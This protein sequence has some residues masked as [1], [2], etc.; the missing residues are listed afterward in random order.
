MKY[1]VLCIIVSYYPD[2]DIFVSNIHALLG[3][4][5]KLLIWENTPAKE[6]SKYRYIRSEKIEYVGNGYNVGI[7]K[8]LN[9]AWKY[10]Q[11]YKFDFLLTMDQD[12]LLE[13]FGVYKNRIFNSLFYNRA[14]F[15]PQKGNSF[16]DLPAEE[17]SHCIIS[18]CMVHIDVLNTIGGY[19][20]NFFVDAIDIEFCY[21]ARLFNIKTFEISGCYLKQR[22][23]VPMVHHLLWKKITSSN[24]SPF[25]LYGIARNYKIV[26]Q[27][28]PY[29]KDVKKELYHMYLWKF[30][31]N[32]LL[33]ESNKTEKL[34]AI[35]SGFLHGKFFK[36]PNVLKIIDKVLPTY[37]V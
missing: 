21:R 29:E 16:L 13:N 35:L 36:R 11:D 18:G 15:S 34:L 31:R 20:E 10:A 6:A 5:D 2:K 7:S 8:A 25:R 14:I 9:F 26:S 23:G 19:L 17:L 28:Y 12:S 32:I 30:P 3:D 37:D 1:K 22:Y 27:L 24:Y 33:F 4:V